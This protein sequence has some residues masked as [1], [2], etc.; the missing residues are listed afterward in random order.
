MKTLNS[1]HNT[2]YLSS[3]SQLSN[4]GKNAAEQPKTRPIFLQLRLRNNALSYLIRFII[5]HWSEY[6]L[7]SGKIT[8]IGLAKWEW[9]S[10]RLK[11]IIFWRVLAN[12]R[13]SQCV[14]KSDRGVAQLHLPEFATINFIHQ[15]YYPSSYIRFVILLLGSRGRSMRECVIN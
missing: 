13:T 7:R 15:S 3:D 2:R 10:S 1:S 9:K 14:Q 6:S 12:D 5:R 4:Q 8:P 11:S